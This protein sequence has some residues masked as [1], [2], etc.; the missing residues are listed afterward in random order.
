MLSDVLSSS[1]GDTVLLSGSHDDSVPNDDQV[2]TD[3]GVL[4]IST[5]NSTQNSPL[6][7]SE[8]EASKTS[9]PCTPT[10]HKRPHPDKDEDDTTPLPQPFPLPKHYRLDVERALSS[11]KMTKDTTCAFLSA[12]AAAMLV[13]KRYP[14][15]SDYVNVARSVVEKYSFFSSPAGTPYVSNIN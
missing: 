12:V 6:L 8:E 9:V 13:Y 3:D 14:S 2:S 7:F 11:G 5:Q 15:K 1:G 10:S 4:N